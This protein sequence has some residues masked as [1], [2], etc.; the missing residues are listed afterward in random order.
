MNCNFPPAL[1][2]ANLLAYLEQRAGAEVTEHLAKCSH[3]AN[4]ASRLARRQTILAR[5]LGRL[6][7]CPSRM[8]LGEYHLRV[9]SQSK[10]ATIR[11]HLA[12]CDYC[13]NEFALLKGYVDEPQ[14]DLSAL[15]VAPVDKPGLI[16]RIRVLIARPVQAIPGGGWSTALAGIRGAEE[17][18]RVY[19]AG[20]VRVAIEVQ[21]DMEQ[22]GRQLLLGLATGLAAGTQIH[23]HQMDQPAAMAQTELDELGNFVLSLAPGE[24]D[25]ILD[26]GS[27]A[28]HLQ[29][30]QV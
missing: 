25:L 5:Q 28:I 13:Q 19:E 14:P 2:E 23:L 21:D 22:P 9:L 11:Q 26:D 16:E 1:S 8:E 29:A 30:I 6:I 10:A 20:E 7:A 24:Y 3:C 4:R 18:A 12:A 27:T 15:A 17:S